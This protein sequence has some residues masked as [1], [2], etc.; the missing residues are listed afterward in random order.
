[1]LIR[2]KQTYT[3]LAIQYD[4]TMGEF[5]CRVTRGIDRYPQEF[6]LSRCFIPIESS[7]AQTFKHLLP[8]LHRLRHL[9]QV[10]PCTACIKSWSTFVVPK[11]Q[12]ALLMDA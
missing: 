7:V 8:D 9:R 3:I 11:Q 1:M 12:I 10:K 2:E 4:K 5:L 6:E